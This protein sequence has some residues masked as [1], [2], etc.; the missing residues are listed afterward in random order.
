MKTGEVMELVRVALNGKQPCT[1]ECVGAAIRQLHKDEP[2]VKLIVSYADM[3]QGHSG[4][5]L[6]LMRKNIIQRGNVNIYGFL[7]N[8]FGKNGRRRLNLIRRKYAA[9]VQR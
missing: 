7:I 1:S 5:T 9:V 3:D 6:T 2:Q 4:H 8:G